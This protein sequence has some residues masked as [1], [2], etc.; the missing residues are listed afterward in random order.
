MFK[1]SSISPA[2]YS[3]RK[4]MEPTY[5]DN[6]PAAHGP[7]IFADT[8]NIEEIR[9]LLKAGIINGVTTNPSLLK[10][11]GAK[12]WPQALQMMKNIIELLHPAP[13]SLELTEIE[14]GKMLC[15]ADELAA[16]GKNAVIKVPVGGYTAIDKDADPHTGLKVLHHL[17]EKGIP[18]NATLIFNTTQAF[19]AA[20]AG[21]TYVSPFLGRLADY[22]YHND[23]PDLTPGNSL[24]RIDENKKDPTDQRVANT[25]FVASGGLRKDAGVRLIQEII[26]TF[27]NYDIQTQVLAASIRNASQLSEVLLSGADII[28][29]PASILS[30]V[31]D[32]PLTDAGMT[33][34]VED[35]KTFT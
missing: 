29:V 31:A 21:A 2:I 5:G 34:F 12:S 17:W 23:L 3:R 27:A 6:H 10:K 4:S 18:T 11:A 20:N 19:W 32:H 9:P 28:T 24:Y 35:A 1:P 8:A 16:I 26:T 13:V 30:G 7:K 15:Q 14:E 33:A 25:E 22:A